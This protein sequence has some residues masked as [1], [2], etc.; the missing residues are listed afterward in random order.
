MLAQ[1]GHLVKS[2]NM[3]NM[4]ILLC[5]FKVLFDGIKMCINE[6]FCNHYTR[7]DNKVMTVIFS[8]LYWQYCSLLNWTAFDLGPS[9]TPTCS[10]MAVQCLSAE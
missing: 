3:F 2:F 8:Y 5:H 7:P 1:R 9:S 6:L 10:G 4:F